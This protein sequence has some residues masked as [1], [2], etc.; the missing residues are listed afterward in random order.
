MCAP[1]CSGTL[2]RRSKALPM[3]S[4]LDRYILRKV[5]TPMT[6]TL[7]IG[8]LML[9]AERLV[10]LLDF[11][12]GKKNS[13]GVVFELLAYLVP[14]YLGTA[15][16]A[17]LFLGLLFGF[18]KL[19]KDNEIDAML[20]AGVGLHRLVRPALL[21]A[22]VFSLASLVIFGWL[23]PHTRHAYRSVIF[24]LRNI[25]AFYLA[26]EGVFMQAGSR[27]FILDKLDR[28]NSRF[29][30]IFIFDYNGPAGAETYTASQGILVPVEGQTRPVLRLE[31]GRRLG[32]E[33]WPTLQASGTPPQPN[34]ATFA[35]SDTPLGKISKDLF[36][37]RGEDEREL[38]LTEIYTQMD[39]PPKGSS[40]EAMR[41]E[42]HRRVINILAMFVLPFLAIPFA[43]G[44]AR[45]P[46]AYRIALAMVMLVAFHE[47]IEQ[48]AVITKNG[49]A[50]PWVALWLPMAALTVFALWRFYLVSFTIA[51]AGLDDFVSGLHEKS[52]GL[53]TR[54]WA[55]RRKAP[56]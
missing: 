11:T 16:P 53:L 22:F 6:A 3:L 19:S 20:A 50:S 30:H 4:T 42:F 48:G 38:T 14:H 39:A 35:V 31:N 34:F 26:E 36:R 13:F 8:L 40:R 43:V 49:A 55:K 32:V 12:L 15:V 1:T 37:P 56:A 41:A 18:N 24:D 29:E 44:R 28:G 33:S 21:L 52:V 2:S 46:R 7:A 5:V 47:I 17:A 25:D 23:Q 45:S 54:L 10:R 51:G 27:T 9:L